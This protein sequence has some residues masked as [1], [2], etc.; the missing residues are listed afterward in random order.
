MV[1]LV[2]GGTTAAR[3]S[4]EA[5]CHGLAPIATAEWTLSDVEVLPPLPGFVGSSFSPVVAHVAQ[6]CLRQAY[7]E[8]PVPPA[9]GD[10]V[11]IL[12][13]SPLGD[14]ASALDVSRRVRA[15]ERVGP[16]L[17]FQSVPHA[18]A[19][20]VAARWGLR[21]PVVCLS[22]TGV[23]LAPA[24]L[25]VADGDADEILLVLVDQV[26]AVAALVRTVGERGP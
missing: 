15:G 23:D 4:Q 6:A 17:F 8:P 10:G 9:V 22:A 7:G 20:F 26:R 14:V 1:T 21:G 5:A 16:L 25:L 11:A 2:G 13:C 18:V 12:I 24:A 19:G 3:V